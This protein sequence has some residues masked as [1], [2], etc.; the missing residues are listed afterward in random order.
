M[1]GKAEARA[2]DARGAERF[3]EALKLIDD[4]VRRARATLELWEAVHA[5]PGRMRE[6]LPLYDDALELLG[7][8]DEELALR[9]EG[10]AL[11]L[12]R[13][14]RMPSHE[15][16]ARLHRIRGRLRDGTPVPP[17]VLAHV[18]YHRA[19]SCSPVQEVGPLARRALDGGRLLAGADEDPLALTLAVGALMYADELDFA[20]AH[21]ETAI[22]RARRHGSLGT[23]CVLGT[24]R[25]GVA[26]RRG[27][28]VEA[29]GHAHDALD[30]ALGHDLVA[31]PIA[32]ACVAEVR[33]E[34]G[35][36][37]EAV[38]L[39][40]SEVEPRFRRTGMLQYLLATRGRVRLAQGR[41]RQALGD[42]LRGGELH[43]PWSRNPAT[44]A[45]RS[46][47]ALAAVLT[48]DRGRALTL[49]AEEERL[50]RAFGAPRARGIALR[51]LGLVEGG[52][53]GLVRLR[54]AVAVLAPSPARLEHARALVDL[55]A[56]QRRA[57]ASRVARDP[58]REGL[59]VAN[60]CGA[61]GLAERARAELIAAGGRPRR[62]ALHGAD[63]LTSSERR[64]TTLAAEGLTNRE[65]AQALFVTTKT[66]EMHLNHAYRK[67]GIG[68]RGELEAA[69]ER[70]TA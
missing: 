52:E 67:L 18:A 66:V 2:A 44:M 6:L 38:A 57:G 51:A 19:L 14:A 65:I 64:I 9:L 63:A 42:L 16:R 70:P 28:L 33:L 5:A 48:G 41:P 1:L 8:A 40:G 37:E 62:E 11:V 58:L 3:Q 69:L 22:E 50:A 43:E 39:L 55:G 60:R 12:A 27:R 53:L 30:A 36:L 56:A 54:E 59:D 21:L 61:R 17:A 47:A 49:A 25:A 7:D 20:D 32:L 26:L 45:W 24:L 35:R 31:E 46:D 29:A 4:P 10:T 15:G 68:S 13:L 23:Y 34:E